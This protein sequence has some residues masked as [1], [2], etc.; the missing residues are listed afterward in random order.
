MNILHL[1]NQL[2]L[3]CGVSNS[4]LNLAYTTRN[5]YKHH[6]LALYGDAEKKFNETGFYPKFLPDSK[7]SLLNSYKAIKFISEYCSKNN[8]DVIHS[9]HRTFDALSF[10]LNK[11]KNRKTVVTVHNIRYDKKLISY[12]SDKII[13]VSE[14]VAMHLKQ[15]YNKESAKIEIIENFINKDLARINNYPA[16]YRSQHGLNEDDFVIMY[17]GRFSEEKGVDILIE[18]YKELKQKFPS[19]RLVLIGEGDEFER[20]RNID[21]S[22]NLDI[23]FIEPVENIFDFLNFANLVIL[24]SRDEAFGNIILEAA[25]MEKPVIASNI[26]NIKNLIKNNETGI[27]FH[28]DDN[29]DL[30]KKIAEAYANYENIKQ[31]GI[32]LKRSLSGKFDEKKFITKIEN[33]Y[34]R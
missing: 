16:F 6:M 4:I 21:R 8:I 28:S 12:N 31:L 24:P 25:Y 30:T 33:C 19:M 10:L 7:I 1:N 26:G 15:H 18:S 13:A 5:K 34:E 32:N 11:I 17:A 9:H 22:S 23:K 3:A 27:M 29:K 14:Y 20:Y 2:N